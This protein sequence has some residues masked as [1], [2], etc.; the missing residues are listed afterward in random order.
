ML[1]F[2]IF[3]LSVTPRKSLGRLRTSWDIIGLLRKILS[4]SGQTCHAYTLKSVDRY[5]TGS[6]NMH[7]FIWKENDERQ[8]ASKGKTE[9]HA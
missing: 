9:I 5:T 8:R 2:L 6:E 1:L 3:L 4:L 7:T